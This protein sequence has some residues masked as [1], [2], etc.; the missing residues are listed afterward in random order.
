MLAKVR[1]SAL[2]GV[3]GVPVDVEVEVRG[4]TPKFTII[5]LGDSAVKE[6]KDRVVSAIR[7]SGFKMPGGPVL[8]SLAPA[9]LK[10]VG[11]SFDLAI[12]LGILAASHQIDPAFFSNISV[13][14]ELSLD[15]SIKGVRGALPMAMAAKS[16]GL[17]TVCVPAVNAASVSLLNGIDVVGV[18]SLGELCAYLRGEFVPPRVERIE[19]RPESVGP[20][21]ANVHGQN[22]AKR[23]LL[24]AAAGAHNALMIG[25]PGCG[26]SLLAEAFRSILPPLLEDEL[27]EVARIHSAAG[28]SV[29]E[30]LG[31]DRPY[32][33]P[34][35]VITDVGLVGGGSAPKPGEISLAHR[36]VLFLDEFPEY[37]R[38]ALE[39]LRAP[40]ENGRVQIVRANGRVEF[41]ARFQLIAAMN[42]CPCGRLGASGVSC[43]CSLNSIQGYLKKLSQPVLDRIDLHVELD[44]VPLSVLVGEEETINQSGDLR[45]QIVVARLKQLERQRRLNSELSGDEIKKIAKLDDQSKRLLEKAG[46]KMGISARGFM[47]VLKVSRTIADLADSNDVGIEHIA[48]ALSFRAIERLTQYA[49]GAAVNG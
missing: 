48:E 17:R 7:A 27:L 21:F 40:L 22:R 35:H 10:K 6:S 23:A 5:G 47:R 32:R 9:E 34:H 46:E 31:G 4:G 24:I 12:A 19:V 49:Q 14:G 13:H 36:G 42:P 25:P 38:T 33:A 15:G 26:K 8:V 2:S 44:P 3:I 43:L 18:D 28:N 37:R 29:E 11:S 41:P 45:E 39:A 16:L 20:S 1:T 30:F